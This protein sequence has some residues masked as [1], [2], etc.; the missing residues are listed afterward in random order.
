[1]LFVVLFLSSCF[2]GSTPKDLQP[3]IDGQFKNA[4]AVY[5]PSTDGKASAVVVDKNG[6]VYYIRLNGYGEL[7][8]NKRLFNVKDYS[9]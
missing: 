9:K 3:I 6:D 8:D 2:G 1:M 4:Q 5:Y 7:R